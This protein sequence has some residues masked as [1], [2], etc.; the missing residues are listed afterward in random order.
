MLTERIC[1]DDGALSPPAE[2]SGALATV[3]SVITG[4]PQ[5]M[6][7]SWLDLAFLNWPVRARVLRQTLPPGVELDCFE[8]QAWLSLVSFQMAGVGV[9]GVPD[10]PGVSVF[11]ELNL[12]TYVLVDGIPAVWFYSLD[13][14]QRVAVEFGRRLYHLPYYRARISIWQEQD[15]LRYES[16]RT[17]PGSPAAEFRGRYRPLGESVPAPA[18]SL[19]DWLTNRLAF[20]TATRSGRVYRCSVRHS[21]WPLQ[22]GEAEITTNSVCSI[23]LGLEPDGAPLVYFSRTLEVTGGLIR[24]VAD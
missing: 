12:R 23:G 8:G 18:G 11:P 4:D 9:R 2:L 19:A 22:A 24:R 15:W 21:P 3:A 7:M 17:H 14:D 16:V 20:V 13:A 10:L 1:E 5:V 6:R